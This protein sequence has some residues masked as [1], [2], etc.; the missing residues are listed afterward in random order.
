MV[1]RYRKGLAIKSEYE[2]GVKVILDYW[3]MNS[4]IHQVGGLFI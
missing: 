3:Y 1:Q 2:V 4:S